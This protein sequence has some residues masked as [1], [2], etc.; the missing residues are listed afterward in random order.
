MKTTTGEKVTPKSPG[1]KYRHYAPTTPVV[2]VEGSVEFW[3]SLIEEYQEQGE[4][5]AVM[6]TNDI[7]DEVRS[8]VSESYS[9]GE[10]DSVA[11]MS[12]HLFN[13]LRSLDHTD[14]TII[15]AQASV[16][17]GAGLAYMNRL[18]KASSDTKKER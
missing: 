10:K 18:E 17:E 2:V 16:K 3:H 4:Q 5:V 8:N 9:L 14:A 1:M 13:A 11:D 6:A 7:L 15:L 12:H